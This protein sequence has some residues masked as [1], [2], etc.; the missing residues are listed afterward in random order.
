ML[1]KLKSIYAKVLN[2]LAGESFVDSNA[3]RSH[4]K[5]K[6]L[7]ISKNQSNL[8]DLKSLIFQLN[9]DCVCVE[10][11]EDAIAISARKFSLI[12][13]DFDKSISSDNLSDLELYF[14][15]PIIVFVNCETADKMKNDILFFS[16]FSSKNTNFVEKSISAEQAYSLFSDYLCGDTTPIIKW[17]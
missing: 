13:L 2:F 14:K 6:V 10:T 7:L 9:H 17:E 12:I 11:I 8:N 3:D 15:I 5:K 1:E 4:S 16:Q